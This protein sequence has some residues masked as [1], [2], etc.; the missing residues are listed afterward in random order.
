MRAEQ[1]RRGPSRHHCDDLF[2]SKSGRTERDGGIDTR[3]KDSLIFLSAL[4]N[5]TIIVLSEV[6]E[7]TLLDESF[8]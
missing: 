2:D 8:T 6:D 4:I 1:H 5:G 7:M 3:G